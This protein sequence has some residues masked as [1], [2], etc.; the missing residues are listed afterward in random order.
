[1]INYLAFRI[2]MCQIVILIGRIVDCR[3]PLFRISQIRM[4]QISI[5]IKIILHIYIPDRSLDLYCE[6]WRDYFINFGPAK[7]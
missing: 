1:M 5:I 4:Y 2:V 7:P 3:Q 6:I